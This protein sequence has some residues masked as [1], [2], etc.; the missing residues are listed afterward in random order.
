MSNRL[1]PGSYFGKLADAGLE[2]I[3]Q[4]GTPAFTMNFTITHVAENGAWAPITEV[5]RNIQLFMTDKARDYALSDLRRLGFNGDFDAPKF[6][7]DVH[8]GLE[9]SLWHETYEGKPQEKLKVARLKMQ[10]ER[11]PIANDTRKTLEALYRGSAPK[12]APAMP[13]A[14]PAASP[15]LSPNSGAAAAGAGEP[16]F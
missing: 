2:A 3:G 14:P 13:P 12:P 5:N 1:A 9:L 6:D 8:E 10:H 16:P 15:P 11:K 7:A 4:N